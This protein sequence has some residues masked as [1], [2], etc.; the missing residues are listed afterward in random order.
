MD[1][2]D[3]ALPR[4]I[5]NVIVIDGSFAHIAN[6]SV[7]NAAS[8]VAIVDRHAYVMS[9]THGLCVINVAGPG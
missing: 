7:L 3:P 4:T 8:D 5:G 2:F 1:V 9:S 6:T